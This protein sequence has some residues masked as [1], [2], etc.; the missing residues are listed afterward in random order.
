MIKANP[1]TN[2]DSESISLKDIEE[3]HALRYN[4]KAGNLNA[5]DF[6]CPQCLNKGFTAFVQ[7]GNPYPYMALKRCECSPI[8]AMIEEAKT[9]SGFGDLLYNS[10][11]KFIATETWQHDLKVLA[12]DYL[13]NFGSNWFAVLGQSGAGKT[14]VC[15][16][17]CNKLLK[18]YKKVRYLSWVEF[19]ELMKSKSNKEAYQRYAL[20]DVLYIDDLL[21]GTANAWDTQ[22]A[23]QLI[24]DRY[25]QN[26]PTI[27]SSE[28]LIGDL[29][30]QDESLAG[31]ILERSGKYYFPIKKEKYRNYR[32]KGHL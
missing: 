29:I 6:D 25:N 12:E 27:I 26:L 13:E 17:I 31:R 20:A 5:S 15:A 24:N 21:K 4:S 16:S 10:L 32:L 9:K 3:L 30:E 8:R 14:M 23:W 7:E 22:I 11:D 1:S 2:T 28:L 18:R 19:S